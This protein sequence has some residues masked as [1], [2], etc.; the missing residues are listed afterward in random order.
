MDG[1][2]TS[3]LF[4]V[5][6]Q[7]LES[8]EIVSA[9]VKKVVEVCTLMVNEEPNEE[10]LMQAVGEVISAFTDDAAGYTRMPG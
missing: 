1:F 5:K 6:P 10:E 3:M 2:V 9:L 4:A 8:P 7:Y